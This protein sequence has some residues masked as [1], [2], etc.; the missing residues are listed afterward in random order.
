LMH[1][2]QSTALALLQQAVDVCPESYI[3]LSPAKTEL[4]R[5]S[6]RAIP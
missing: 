4:K 1:G 6:Q 2:N 3:E 5:L